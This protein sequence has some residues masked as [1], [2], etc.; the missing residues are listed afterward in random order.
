MNGQAARAWALA[1]ALLFAGVGSLSLGPAWQAWRAVEA[2]DDP[3]AHADLGLDA[4]LTKARLDAEIDAALNKEDDDLAASFMTL[5]TERGLP[6]DPGQGRRL[7][8]LRAQADTRAARDFQEGF[9]HGERDSA[10]AFAGATAS[11]LTGYGDVRDLVEQGRKA[12]NGETV[13]ETTVWIAAAGL[14]VSATTWVSLGNLLPARTGLSALKTLYKTG[15]LSRLLAASLSRLAAA[16]VDRGALE[17][18]TA[19]A[20]RLDLAG[21]RA[22]APTLLRPGALSTF[23]AL[24][25][26]AAILLERTGA[27]GAVQVAGLAQT[28]AELRQAAR[29]ALTKGPTTRAILEVLGRS[30]LIVGALGA[31]AVS[32][33]LAFAAYAIG[34]AMLARR[35]G[36][37]LGRRLWRRQSPNGTHRSFHSDQ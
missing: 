28:R 30:A 31:S 20:L 1:G 21:L 15:R 24:E 29:L 37:W 7:E 27:R 3:A 22:A 9:L 26:D 16:A 33:L 25:R 8:A 36:C 19:A 10:A 11:D 23:K 17:K 35:F 6:I 13:D 5:A 14:A 32:W 34:L 2:G 4:A 12:A 18:G